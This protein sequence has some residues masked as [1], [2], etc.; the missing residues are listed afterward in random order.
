MRESLAEMVIPVCT[1]EIRIMEL[2]NLNFF[3]TICVFSC[4]WY[5]RDIP[6]ITCPKHIYA[7]Q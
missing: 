2:R 3:I 7:V 6:S 5:Y 1:N 4:K